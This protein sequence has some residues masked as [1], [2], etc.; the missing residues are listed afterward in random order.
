MAGSNLRSERC[1]TRHFYFPETLDRRNRSAFPC[2]WR[3]AL[4][5]VSFDLQANCGRASYAHATSRSRGD[6]CRFR[7]NRACPVLT[8]TLHARH[9]RR[10]RALSGGAGSAPQCLLSSP[11]RF[12]VV[13]DHR[14]QFWT[15]SG[16]GDRRPNHG[17][18]QKRD[19]FPCSSFAI[20]PSAIFHF[21]HLHSWWCWVWE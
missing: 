5:L 11:D 8:R 12:R 21:C 18:C 17:L 20:L 1:R 3:T 6:L 4:A 14:I 2:P 10:D 9:H 16:L 15:S 19:V 13:L 7:T